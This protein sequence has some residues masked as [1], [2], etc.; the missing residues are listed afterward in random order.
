ETMNGYDTT[1]YSIDT[2]R[3]DAAEAGLYRAT[4]GDGG[5][6]KG[7]AWVTDKGCPV[8][9][10]LDSEMHLTNGSVDKVHYEIAMVKK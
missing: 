4:L 5:F 2:S 9:L 7:I 10:S 3:G 8:K 1:R 6:E